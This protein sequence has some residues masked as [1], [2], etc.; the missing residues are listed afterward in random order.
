MDDFLGDF[1]PRHISGRQ[2][3][4]DLERLR[5]AE[6]RWGLRRYRTA[7]DMVAAD[8]DRASR[9]V[10]SLR[11]YSRDWY[12]CFDESLA[13]AELALA[14]VR[15]RRDAAIK[16]VW[17]PVASIP[18]CE[19]GNGVASQIS[20]RAISRGVEPAP[21]YTREAL[22]MALKRHVKDRVRHADEATFYFWHSIDGTA[23]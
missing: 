2:Q 11:K 14:D 4:D 16:P 8:T 15:S 21:T 9:F 1:W 7:V 22:A 20:L 3:H 23:G 17:G 13:G 5:R 19:L 6:D 10:R 12:L 18:C